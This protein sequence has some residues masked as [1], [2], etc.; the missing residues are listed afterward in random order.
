MVGI[1]GVGPQSYEGAHGGLL[2]SLALRQMTMFLEWRIIDSPKIHIIRAS[3][4]FTAA[5]ELKPEVLFNP[6]LLLMINRKSLFG[7]T[8]VFF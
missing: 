8:F 2:A 1:A 6:L 5:G 3:E 7:K 4:R